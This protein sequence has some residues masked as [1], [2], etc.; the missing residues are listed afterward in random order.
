MQPLGTIEIEGGHT[1][2]GYVGGRLQRG[3]FQSLYYFKIKR[4]LLLRVLRVFAQLRAH[5]TRVGVVFHQ[6]HFGLDVG[7][8]CGMF[9]VPLV[10]FDIHYGQ[11]R[12]QVDLTWQIK[13][14]VDRAD[15]VRVVEHARVIFK[16][17]IGRLNGQLHRVIGTF[18][19]EQLHLFGYFG[20]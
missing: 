20:P 16:L 7:V 13:T 14:V 12:V 5:Q 2:N 19:L 9:L 3:A 11:R 6:V 4:G 17:M 18:L 8:Q 10:K 15:R 1:Q